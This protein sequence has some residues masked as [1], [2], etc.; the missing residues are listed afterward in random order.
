MKSIERLFFKKKKRAELLVATNTSEPLLFQFFKNAN[1]RTEGFPRARLRTR[2]HG[3][4]RVC[5]NHRSEQNNYLE[6][7][8]NYE[9]T[10]LLQDSDGVL[11]CRKQASG[12][13][14]SE[15]CCFLICIIFNFESEFYRREQFIVLWAP[16]PG[17]KSLSARKM[18]RSRRANLWME[19]ALKSRKPNFL[20][21]TI[22]ALEIFLCTYRVHL[23]KN[24]LR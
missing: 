3:Q 24:S 11:D 22:L 6:W 20:H 23:K 13:F 18:Q 9:S 10:E 14:C 21:W 7:S 16:A 19:M 4:H 5:P 15:F 12:D 2:C 8:R 17:T 1:G